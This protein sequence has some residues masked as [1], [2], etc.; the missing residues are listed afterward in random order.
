MR[1]TLQLTAFLF[2]VPLILVAQ[3]FKEQNPLTLSIVEEPLTL[4]KKRI[5]GFF[6]YQFEAY[7]NYYSS[8]GSRL[9]LIDQNLVSSM[10]QIQCFFEYG[11]NNRFQIGIY[12][13]YNGGYEGYPTETKI[14][15]SHIINKTSVKKINGFEDVLFNVGFNFTP[16]NEKVEVALF[17]GIYIP[18]PNKPDEPEHSITE[19]LGYD[20]PGINVDETLNENSGTGSFRFELGSKNK[21]RLNKKLAFQT[22]L[23]YCFPL[24]KANSV[25]WE[26]IY[27][28]STYKHI[29]KDIHYSPA[30]Q[31]YYNIELL[32][33]PDKK[34]VM[35]LTFGIKSMTFWNARI[36]DDNL[37]SDNQASRLTNVY[38]SL[39]LIVT[40]NLRFTQQFGY[41]ITG[42]NSKGAFGTKT[43][44]TFNF[45]NH[46]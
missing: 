5:K 15:R 30:K 10:N 36:E 39:E 38:T 31:F 41:D 27:D 33:V 4:Q 13:K 19:L 14:Y 20:I 23:A 46:E 42:R 24:S 18:M 11:L 22:Q 25:N 37:V 16:K 40:D 6:G 43:S 28:G 29:S 26:T 35:G 2:F 32:L 1:T 44:L 17:P 34:E 9:N 45:M 12:D 21:F 3:T 8:N 7:R